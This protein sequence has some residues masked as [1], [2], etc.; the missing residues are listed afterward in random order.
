MGNI[1]KIEDDALSLISNGL[2]LA[3]GSAFAV[4]KKARRVFGNEAQD[5]MV[6]EEV[7]ELLVALG[8]LIVAIARRGRGRGSQEQVDEEVADVL[9]V[10]LGMLNENSLSVLEQKTERLRGLI[11]EKTK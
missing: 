3:L 8:G 2:G 9:L 7:G 4:A 1:G 5:R 6:N 11:E 10:T